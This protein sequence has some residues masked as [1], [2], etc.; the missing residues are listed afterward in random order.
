MNI[1]MAKHLSMGKLGCKEV[2]LGGGG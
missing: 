2:F 1:T